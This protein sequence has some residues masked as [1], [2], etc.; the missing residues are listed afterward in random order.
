M[1]KIIISFVNGG[2]G[3]RMISAPLKFSWSFI[4]IFSNRE[5]KLRWLKLKT[6][7]RNNFRVIL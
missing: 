4:L 2:V 1:Q 5:K 7:F 6:Q 3:V